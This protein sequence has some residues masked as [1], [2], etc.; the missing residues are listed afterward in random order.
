M[1][2][3]QRD[4]IDVNYQDEMLLCIISAIESTYAIHIINIMYI[5]VE[6][7]YVYLLK[8]DMIFLK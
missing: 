4:K 2:N 7:S 3:N 6:M 5:V 8:L 1:Q